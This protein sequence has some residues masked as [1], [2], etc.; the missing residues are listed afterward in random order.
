[1]INWQQVKKDHIIMVKALRLLK[2]NKFGSRRIF[3]T[4]TY[5]EC[6][7]EAGAEDEAHALDLSFMIL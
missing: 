2:H 7:L 4:K 6:L 5:L 3:K 1:M